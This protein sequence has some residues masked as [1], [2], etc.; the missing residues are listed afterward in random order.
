MDNTPLSNHLRYFKRSE[1]PEWVP[2]G[3]LLM[4]EWSVGA[5]KGRKG[6]F[7]SQDEKLI[8]LHRR[9]EMKYSWEKIISFFSEDP[10]W[11]GAWF[12]QTLDYSFP[13]QYSNL[14]P[15][16]A[17]KAKNW[18]SGFAKN[19]LKSSRF[20]KSVPGNFFGWEHEFRREVGIYLHRRGQHNAHDKIEDMVGELPPPS[21]LLNSMHTALSNA[22]N[23]H[24]EELFGK[25][26]EGDNSSRLYFM[27]SLTSN[28]VQ[29][30]TKPLRKVVAD[31]A[32]VGFDCQISE[33]EVI[34][35][36]KGISSKE[37]IVHRIDA[38]AETIE[39]VLGRMQP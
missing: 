32:S 34:R 12:S 3:A 9:D 29:A 2:T 26:P 4:L 1:F 30:T 7:N 23:W 19:L 27:R 17:T 11:G 37:S 33:R 38:E 16:S 20:A 28:L 31:A 25:Q 14:K 10:D 21:V 24:R 36:C 22:Y 39:R 13:P 8:S 15:V 5:F 35:A 18:Q 6:S